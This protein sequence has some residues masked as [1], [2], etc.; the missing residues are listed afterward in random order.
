VD[1]KRELLVAMK[2]A[3]AGGASTFE[4]SVDPKREDFFAMGASAEERAG[5]NEEEKIRTEVRQML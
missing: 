1:P 3:G 2:A 5:E 4:A